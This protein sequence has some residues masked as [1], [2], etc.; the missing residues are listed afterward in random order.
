MSVWRDT[1]VSTIRWLAQHDKSVQDCSSTYMGVIADRYIKKVVTFFSTRKLKGKKKWWTHC[2]ISSHKLSPFSY[3]HGLALSLSVVE[4]PQQKNRVH[5][6]ESL[7]VSS[8]TLQTTQRKSTKVNQTGWAHEGTL[9]I[10]GNRGASTHILNICS[11]I[12]GTRVYVHRDRTTINHFVQV[13][14]ELVVNKLYILK[15]V[16]LRKFFFVLHQPTK[17]KGQQGLEA[18]TLKILIHHYRRVFFA[19]CYSQWLRICTHRIFFLS[20]AFRGIF[21]ICFQLGLSAK[22]NEPSLMILLFPFFLSYPCIQ[23]N[24]T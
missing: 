24:C 19:V 21:L 5:N 11:V 7:I 13:N 1:F 22:S 14:Q 8:G 23:F 17:S 4:S 15:R 6:L 12:H 10:D 3:L 18:S 20:L 16:F 2:T 9:E